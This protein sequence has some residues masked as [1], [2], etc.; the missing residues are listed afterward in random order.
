MMYR[1]VEFKPVL[2]FAAAI[3]LLVVILY[4]VYLL[5]FVGQ[6]LPLGFGDTDRGEVIGESTSEAKI[7]SDS[8]GPSSSP[9]ASSSAVKAVAASPATQSK[10]NKAEV[11]N[12]PTPTPAAEDKKDPR[13][14]DSGYFRYS[15]QPYMTEY[16]LKGLNVQKGTIK[17]KVTPDWGENLEYNFKTLVLANFNGEDYRNLF[18][19]T[20]SQADLTFD[21]YDSVAFNGADEPNYLMGNDYLGK[22]YDVKFRWDF[23][24]EPVKQIFI[25]GV[26]VVETRPEA[27]PT[28]T[29]GK[30]FIGP[31]TDLE[32]SDE[33]KE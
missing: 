20:G 33:W 1:K 26:L 24:S 11:V 22:S 25:N 27:K 7:S 13:Y 29:N 10:A 14:T 30:I 23:T 8:V 4:L 2:K 21:T 15:L 6:K 32:I 5:F 9:T 3:L 28:E 17:F 18:E 31:V 12:S 16:S 19:I